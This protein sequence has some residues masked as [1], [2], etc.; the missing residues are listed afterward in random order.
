M[1]H[2]PRTGLWAGYAVLTACFLTGF[3]YRFSPATFAEELGRDLGTSATALG[4]LASW[5]FWVYTAAQIPAGTAV[6]RWGARRSAAAGSAIAAA[7]ALSLATADGFL[8]A[9]LG[10]ILTGLGMSAVF[11]AAMKY[12]AARF[13]PRHYGLVTGLTM[14]LANIGSVAAGS[15]SAILLEHFSWRAVFLGAAALSTALA[16]ASVAAVRDQTPDTAARP[17]REGLSALAGRKGLWPVFWCTIGTNATFYSF[18]GLWGTPLLGDGFGLATSTAAVYSTVALT[19]Y[20]LGSL[21][22]GIASDKAGRRKPFLVGTSAAAV[23]GWAALAAA[24]WSPGPSGLLLYGL[25]GLAASQVTVSFAAVK[26]LAPGTAA[27]KAL[28]LV[29]AGVFGATAVL[30]PL[31]GRVLD[32]AGGDSPDLADYRTA[33]AL[34]LALSA[35]GLATSLRTTETHCRDLHPRP[36]PARS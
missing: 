10:P 5:H 23:A 30:Q 11:V 7:G 6:D 14:L 20:G 8:Q 22:I 26:E 15:P 24:P 35:I 27:G 31:F 16:L 28:A 29:N 21:L 19:L 17:P 13:E 2:R 4:A 25:V 1:P 18:S 9:S 32:A 36:E 34:P 3:F 33:L 12:N